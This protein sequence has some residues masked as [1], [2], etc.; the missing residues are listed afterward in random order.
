MNFDSQQMCIDNKSFA[1]SR[2]ARR[3]E[4]AVLAM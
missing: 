2:I 4:L 3:I 1:F